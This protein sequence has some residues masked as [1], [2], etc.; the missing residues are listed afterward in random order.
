MSKNRNEKIRD[1][2]RS[3]KMLAMEVAQCSDPTL[4]AKLERRFSRLM[5]EKKRLKRRRFGLAGG[6]KSSLQYG[7]TLAQA[8]NRA[9]FWGTKTRFMRGGSMSRK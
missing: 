1:I 5:I 6:G 3:M 2:E 4:R 7:D 9:G 8:K